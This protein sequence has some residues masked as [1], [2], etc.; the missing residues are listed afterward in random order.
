MYVTHNLWATRRLDIQKLSAEWGEIRSFEGVIGVEVGGGGG[1][2]GVGGII[3]LTEAKQ[4]GIMHRSVPQ[5]LY[6]YSR[7]V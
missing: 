2:G 5:I 3:L 6:Y 7:T 4:K 1:G